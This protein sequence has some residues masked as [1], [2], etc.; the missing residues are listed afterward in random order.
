MN[1]EKVLI[2][3]DFKLQTEILSDLSQFKTALT[4]IKTTFEL[5]EIGAFTNDVFT[6]I[7]TNGVTKIKK[8]YFAE[9]DRQLDQSGVKN[10]KLRS[11]VM[12]GTGEAI[13]NFSD[14]INQL[15]NVR[16][17]GGATCSR[18]RFL[19][20]NYISFDGKAFIIAESDKTLILDTHCKTFLVSEQ[21]KETYQVFKN[22]QTS[23]IA[24]SALKE[25]LGLPENEYGHAG[26]LIEQIINPKNEIIIQSIAWI[27]GYRQSRIDNNY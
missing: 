22:L 16:P 5:L 11:I 18:N 24:F 3:T 4:N 12:Q 10:S 1:I 15:V 13:N 14:A 27:N 23:L 8:A 20:L 19:T 26:Q 9:L 17:T 25:K 7:K 21:D 2:D 6:D